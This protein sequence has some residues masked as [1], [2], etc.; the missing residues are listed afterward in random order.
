MNRLSLLQ[1]GADVDIDQRGRSR[2]RRLD[3]SVDNLDRP[4]MYLTPSE[5]WS[6]IAV[7]AGGIPTEREAKANLQKPMP[8]MVAAMSCF[9]RKARMPRSED[10]S[11]VIGRPGWIMPTDLKKTRHLDPSCSTLLPLPGVLCSLSYRSSWFAVSLRLRWY[12]GYILFD[13]N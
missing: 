1:D 3:S 7:H 11:A 6:V 8:C 2:A 9:V 4:G 10:L 12:A 5:S 13:N